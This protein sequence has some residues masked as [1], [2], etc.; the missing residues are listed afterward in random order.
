MVAFVFR[1]LLRRGAHKHHPAVHRAAE[2]PGLGGRCARRAFLPRPE[3]RGLP[4]IPVI[5]AG[6]LVAVRTLAT[7]RREACSGLK[8]CI[9]HPHDSTKTLYI[10]YIR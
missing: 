5:V 7:G 3:R 4:R 1:G 6:V 2:N 9:F 10:R 8:I